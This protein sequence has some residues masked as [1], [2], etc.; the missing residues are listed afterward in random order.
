MVATVTES[1][2][3]LAELRER[4]LSL[5]PGT[6]NEILLDLV[7]SLRPP[8]ARGSELGRMLS[9]RSEEL[10]SGTRPTYS[11]DEVMAKLE[12]EFGEIPE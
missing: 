11:L 5:S 4:V 7:V 12:A 8:G 3:D 6:R 2:A 10:A 1:E 9:E